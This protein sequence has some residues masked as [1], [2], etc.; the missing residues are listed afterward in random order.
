MTITPDVRLEYLEG[1]ASTMLRFKP[2]KWGKMMSVEE[3]VALLTEFLE[4]PDALV[5][6]LTLSPAGAIVPCLG[7]PASLKSKGV[8]FVK[9]KPRNVSKD[10]YKDSLLYGDLSPAPVDQLIAVVEEVGAPRGSE[11]VPRGR[12]R[13]PGHGDPHGLGAGRRA[14]RPGW[15]RR[16]RAPAPPPG[17]AAPPGAVVPSTSRAPHTVPA[18]VP[19]HGR[20][21]PGPCGHRRRVSPSWD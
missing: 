1:V 6:V 4:K 18:P 11:L 7:F 21:R 20:R 12:A 3:N 13:S 14:G 17:T 2:D 10:S 15:L 19:S 5:L 9:K 16:T 8:Y